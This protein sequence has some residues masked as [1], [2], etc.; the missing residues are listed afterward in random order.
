MPATR[1]LTPNLRNLTTRRISSTVRRMDFSSNA[2]LTKDLSAINVSSAHITALLTSSHK[3][4]TSRAQKMGAA[5]LTRKPIDELEKSEFDS[6][7]NWGKGK[8]LKA[9][10][11]RKIVCSSF[12]KAKLNPV[13]INQIS[14]MK[15]SDARLYM[16]EYF[17]SGGDM[18]TV[19]QWLSMA[20][21][22]IR[23]G[24]RRKI[25]VAG[26]WGWVFKKAA[27]F[28]DAIGD[29]VST[30]VDAVLSAGKS[31]ADAVKEA[32][33]WAAKEIDNLVDALVEAGKSIGEI[34]AEAVKKGVNIVKKFV[35]ALIKAGKTV[36]SILEVAFS[37]VADALKKVVRALIQLGKEIREIIVTVANRA[38]SIIKT[39]LE[40][41]LA[42]GIRLVKVIESICTNIQEA[43]R[44]GFIKGLIAIGRSALTIMEEAL[45]SSAAIAALAL[46]AIL[47][48]LGGHRSLTPTER[49][50]AKK[51]FGC[52]IDLDRVKIA[53]GS[54]PADVANLINGE[55]PFTTMYVINFASWSNVNPQTL[56]HELA[57][58]WQA[59]VD[60]PVY[61]VEAIRSQLVGQGYTVTKTILNN[62]NGDIKNLEREQQAT[63]VEH[64]WLLKGTENSIGDYNEDD[65]KP[66]AKQVYKPCT[67]FVR[68]DSVLPVFRRSAFN[69]VFRPF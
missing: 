35:D 37:Y 56:I 14:E 34:L 53:A 48:A 55:R 5:L 47:E 8:G 30:V 46:S 68:Y 66:L 22:V 41:I 42:E 50:E 62:A 10:E 15:R 44:K 39:V 17:N 60:G 28:G 4:S 43:F 59:V 24:G 19:S 54:L 20:G 9:T 32:V 26:A 18:K 52:S 21:G 61:M 49:R 1:I 69:A 12:K 38:L 23:K 6:L 25:G 27:D 3:I 67:Q 11:R 40:G 45:K 7:S 58:V 36:F 63:V 57:H 16:Q 33:N 51:I 2:S 29:A 31:V 13:L 65:L 64:Y